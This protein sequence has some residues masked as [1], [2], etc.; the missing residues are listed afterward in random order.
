[1]MG[2]VNFDQVVANAAAAITLVSIVSSFVYRFIKPRF[3]KGFREAISE[4]VDPK[5][6]KTAVEIKK[7]KKEQR[8]LKKARLQTV[9]HDL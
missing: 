8:R 7:I 3:K 1:M 4:V 2:T 6:A 9:N 5:F